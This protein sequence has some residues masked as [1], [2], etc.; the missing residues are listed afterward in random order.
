M[1]EPYR[2]APLVRSRKVASGFMQV[3]LDA[4]AGIYRQVFG[5]RLVGMAVHGSAVTG[6]LF[7]GLSDLD[8]V[9]VLSSSLTLSD[10]EALATAL[11]AVDI[12]PFAYVQATYHEGSKPTSTLV[13]GG[14]SV[15][16]GAIDDA[17]LHTDAS[18]RSAGERW[19][20]ALPDIVDQDTKDWS[21]AVARRPRQLR[22]ILTRLKPTVRAYLVAKGEEPITTYRTPWHRTHRRSR[23]ART[24]DRDRAHLSL[25]P[26][27]VGKRKPCRRRNSGPRP[28]A[29]G[30]LPSTDSCGKFR[31]AETRA[32][33][34]CRSGCS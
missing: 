29:R 7:P 15:I 26:A 4:A 20:K 9:V 8:L 27:S 3:I 6:D 16:A 17:F 32:D 31:H 12:A 14:H 28:A 33:R 34:C 11:D 30:Y 18:L 19:L 13:P 5:A 22:L 1:V 2:A 25:G 24:I 23:S 21:V 10:S